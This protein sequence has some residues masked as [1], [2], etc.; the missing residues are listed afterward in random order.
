[1]RQKVAGSAQ[2][3]QASR[4]LLQRLIGDAVA[5]TQHSVGHAVEL[6]HEQSHN[7]AGI[8]ASLQESIERVA[9]LQPAGKAGDGIVLYLLAESCTSVF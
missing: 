1:M 8:C 7:G 9:K 4:C 6:N 3:S 5:Q 2:R